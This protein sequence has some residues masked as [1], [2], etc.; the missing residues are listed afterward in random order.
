MATLT[1]RLP[2]DQHQRLKTLAAR[3][4]VSLNKLFE[5]FSVQALAEADA[6]ARFLARAARGD[7]KTGLALLDK[8]DAAY[9]R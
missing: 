6:E 5:A 2:D 8:L 4:G 7:A 3:R 1:I 9:G